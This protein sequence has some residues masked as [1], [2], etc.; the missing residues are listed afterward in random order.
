MKVRNV[1]PCGDVHRLRK[2]VVSDKVSFQRNLP[3]K[4]GGHEEE[5][6]RCG[7]DSLGHKGSRGRYAGGGSDSSGIIGCMQ[8]TIIHP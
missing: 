3:L 7:A 2:N 8:P 6:V 1:Y 5:T 4:K